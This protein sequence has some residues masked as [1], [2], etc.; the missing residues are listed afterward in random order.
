MQQIPVGELLSEQSV[1]AATGAFERLHGH[2]LS[3][4]SP[5]EQAEARAV[6]REQAEV[7]LG[8]VQAALSGA[9]DRDGGWASITLI[10]VGDDGVDVA[11]DFHPDLREVGP[12]Q[13]E[14]TPAQILALAALDA[15]QAESDD[16]FQQ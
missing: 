14:G 3:S 7:V 1:A 11:A 9:P 2:H 4:M 10:D 6:W 8:A 5:D 13:V 15:I 12:D 16:G